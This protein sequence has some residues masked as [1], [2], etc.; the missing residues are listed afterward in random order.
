[1]LYCR[2]SCDIIETKAEMLVAD[3]SRVRQHPQVC[4]GESPTHTTAPDR[5]RM[6]YYTTFHP[7]LQGTFDVFVPAIF[8][9]VEY[10]SHTVQA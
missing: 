8:C 9:K 10:A 2:E 1:M 3:D 6:G 7:S 4:T 5:F